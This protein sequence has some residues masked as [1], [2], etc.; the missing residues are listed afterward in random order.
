MQKGEIMLDYYR[1]KEVLQL[2]DS[3]KITEAKSAL[4][5]LQ[6]RH[7]ALADENTI[8]KTQLQEYEDILYISKIKYKYSILGQIKKKRQRTAAPAA[9]QHNKL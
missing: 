1:Y 5:E 2:F 6:A 9:A 3:N 8:L 7:I 4:M